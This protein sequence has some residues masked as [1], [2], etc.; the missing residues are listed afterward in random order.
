MSVLKRK[1]PFSA[2]I[3][4]ILTVALGAQTPVTAP[5]N[6]YSPADDV[7]LGQEAAQQVAARNARHAR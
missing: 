1:V 7:K 3:A 2:A 4:T 6:K 5:K